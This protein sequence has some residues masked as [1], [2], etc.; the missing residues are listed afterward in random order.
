MTRKKPALS[1]D[2]LLKLSDPGYQRGIAW[3][4]DKMQGINEALDQGK[5]EDEIRRILLGS[6]V[7]PQKARE[8]IQTAKLSKNDL[9]D[10]INHLRDSPADQEDGRKWKPP[11]PRPTV[12]DPPPDDSDQC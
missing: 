6:G 9:T 11:K 8:L 10:T 1:Q 2:T 4:F 3:R 5:N 12:Y 7:T